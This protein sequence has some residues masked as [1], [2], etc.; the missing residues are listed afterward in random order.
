M[1]DYNVLD[2]R[3]SSIGE[4]SMLAAISATL[5]D[6][7]TGRVGDIVPFDKLYDGIRDTIQ[8][9]ANYRI[10]QAENRLPEGITHDLGVRLLKVLLL[11]RHV[12]GFKA[13]PR[14]LRIL[15]TD[16]F[17]EDVMTLETQ[18]KD[19]LH[20]LERQTFVQRIGTSYHYLTN[21]EQDI[22]QEIK[23]TV[24]DV[25]EVTAKFKGM[26]LDD[27]LGDMRVTYGLQKVP[28]RYGLKIDDIAQNVPRPLWLNVVTSFNNDDRE[29]AIT[30]SMGGLD[31]ITMLIDTNDKTLFD[32][33]RMH[34]KTST[35]ISRIN[36]DS[37]SKTRRSIIIDK[38]A[39][40]EEAEH[41]LSG[42]LS[43]AV[44]KSQ[45]YYNGALVDPHS[46]DPH[47][48]I[49][50]AMQTLISKRYT[51]FPMIGKLAYQESDIQRVYQEARDTSSALVPDTADNVIG[52]PAEDIRSTVML[53]T[54]RNITVSVKDLLTRYEEAPYGWPSGVT[55][56]CIAHLAGSRSIDL[57][58]D[59]RPL[60]A[61][62]TVNT[63][64]DSK[65][66]VNILVS[67]PRE[68]D[69]RR[70][71]TLRKFAKEFLDSGVWPS[72]PVDLAHELKESLNAYVN[73]LQLTVSRY[74]AF[75]F[76]NQLTPIINQISSAAKQDDSWLI[77]EFTGDEAEPNIN[78][79]LDEKEDVIDP[80][81]AFLNGQQCAVFERS[82]EWMQQN[83][84]NI[85]A[86]S[87]DLQTLFKKTQA[88]ANSP[89]I[90]RGVKVNQLKI[91]VD[92][93]RTSVSNE[94]SDA[95]QT[96][97]DMIEDIRSNI[98]DTDEYRDA[99]ME[100][101]EHAMSV[102]DHMADETNQTGLILAVLNIQHRM[103]SI[104]ARL[105]NELA[106]ANT[107]H[108]A[109]SS[110]ASPSHATTG[111]HAESAESTGEQLAETFIPITDISRPSHKP[112]ASV[113]D[114]D[115]Y[116]D[117]YRRKLIE[118]IQQGKKILP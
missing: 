14:N 88:I 47:A 64:R 108:T 70:V 22:E 80:I 100:A 2:G 7:H 56:A 76:V 71:V 34:A 72:A 87:S 115:E 89:D 111:K 17:D 53:D 6:D 55:L 59:G 105:I 49:I 38:R 91:M 57:T 106:S 23:N 79:L 96:T 77:N 97:I 92:T 21:E 25:N 90:Y 11:V 113:A 86:S 84:P 13:T 104:Y 60:P 65:K 118:A 83:E 16:R 68:Y 46:S 69:Q 29:K 28:F 20:E 99:P 42:R 78:M 33:L 50:E 26:L 93:L 10:N 98:Q 117:A 44:S 51:N 24:L 95:R 75:T 37:Q 48:R 74:G 18:I 4:R 103:Q 66:R 116:L 39:D 1:S 110:P 109:N 82:I 61:E 27:I 101:Q 15:L 62:Q 3:H 67:T 112:L 54:K 36:A 107:P 73:K 31:T 114:V 85:D 35:F 5:R 40:L 63:L 8:S 45:F 58:L 32:D 94:L 9:T 12:E 19:V 30:Q 52:A 81:I 102:L 41:E 43:T